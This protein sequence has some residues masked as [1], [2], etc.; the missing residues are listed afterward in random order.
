MKVSPKVTQPEAI[1]RILQD[2]AVCEVHLTRVGLPLLYLRLGEMVY[3]RRLDK[4]GVIERGVEEALILPEEVPLI[5]VCYV[6]F[7]PDSLA[8]VWLDHQKREVGQPALI[9]SLGKPTVG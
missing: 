2:P 4:R 1:A 6:R 7:W 3:S 8:V 9:A 5:N